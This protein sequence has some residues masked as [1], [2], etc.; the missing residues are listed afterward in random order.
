MR[1]VCAKQLDPRGNPCR[2]AY[3]GSYACCYCLLPFLGCERAQKKVLRVKARGDDF[4]FRSPSSGSPTRIPSNSR[5]S[6]RNSCSPIQHFSFSLFKESSKVFGGGRMASSRMI[7]P[8]SARLN[9][10]RKHPVSNVA[11]RTTFWRRPVDRA[12]ANDR[13]EQLVDKSVVDRGTP[14]ACPI[15]P[16]SLGPSSRMQVVASF[17]S[18]LADLLDRAFL[19][20]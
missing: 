20:W 1:E 18:L 5:P 4:S 3:Q 10:C 11:Q 12:G 14:I 19:E 7:V 16:R 2:P 6:C 13:R 15:E 17:R 9:L 8:S